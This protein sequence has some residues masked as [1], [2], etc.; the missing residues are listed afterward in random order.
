MDFILTYVLEL[1]LDGVTQTEKC[2]V[3]QFHLGTV[4]TRVLCTELDRRHSFCI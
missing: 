2:T 3:Q 1:Y 4:D